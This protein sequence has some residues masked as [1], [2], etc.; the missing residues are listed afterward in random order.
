MSPTLNVQSFSRPDASSVIKRIST[1]ADGTQ[2][3]GASFNASFSLDEQFVVFTSDASNLVSSDLNSKV[4]IF[5]KN[6]ATG[7]VTLILTAAD[8]SQ[9]NGHS[10]F[11]SW[12]SHSRYVV[13]VSLA[14]NLVSGDTN[15]AM[16]VF[17]KDLLTGTVIRVST[18]T[19]DTQGNKTS[20]AATISLDGRYV[21]FSSFA[22]NLVAGDTNGAEDVFVKDLDTGTLTCISQ[23]SNGTIGNDQSTGP[24]TISPDGRRV[25]FAS[26]ASNLING[27]TNGLD[28]IFYKSLDTNEIVRVSTAVDGAQT[29]GRSTQPFFSADGRYI[30]FNSAAS[31]L[32]AGDTNG[33][34][35]IFRKDL[36]TGAITRLSVTAD[37]SQANN[38]SANVRI[39]ADG[40]FVIFESDASNLVD[41]DTNNQRDIFRKDLVTGAIVRLSVAADGTQT[42]AHQFVEALSSN[43]RY[44][45]FSGG[46]SNLVPGDT[47]GE[48]DLFLVDVERIA[49][50]PAIAAGRLIE[51]RLGV[52]SASS[53]SLA[54]GDGTTS[55]AT[56]ANGSA[57]FNHSYA[58]LGVKAATA[59]VHEGSQSWAV[60]YLIDLAS[61][62]MTR[63][64]AAASQLT[65][66]KGK[67]RLTGDAFADKIYGGYGNDT[68]TG[69]TGK[70]VFVF[71]A[72]LGTHKTDR[73]VNFDTLRDYKVKDDSLWLDN[74]IFTKLGKKGSESKPKKLDKKFFKFADKLQDK[75]DYLIYNKTTGVLSYDKDGSD[76]KYKPVE[77]AK[78]AKNLKMSYHE[79]FVV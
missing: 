78:L 12:N 66:G 69:G 43:G 56:P 14:S 62:T 10:I 21:V 37:G 36:I 22:S 40:R 2:G 17:R 28:D 25:V 6:L 50:G 30:L 19:D 60:P 70:D 48:D 49:E 59:T 16:D 42:N 45:I 31:N 33:K 61:G 39:S 77:I 41:G 18:A 74:K 68:L 32:V 5:R 79:F 47:N 1:A 35:D 71:N 67:D 11:S 65:G 27:D 23:N 15:N 4:D 13:F 51:L 58:S 29:N 26:S 9:S 57:A 34:E 7:E 52:G 8:G 24:A 55:T 3:N 44:A 76:T 64:A 73:K 20:G 72:K 75:D 54:W 53:V 46:G 63:N 38:A